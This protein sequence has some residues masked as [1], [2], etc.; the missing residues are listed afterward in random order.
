MF[1]VSK[2]APHLFHAKRPARSHTQMPEYKAPLRDIRF[3][4]HELFHIE[5]HYA[6]FPQTAELSTELIDAMLDEIERGYVG[7]ES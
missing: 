2:R 5:Q 6:R 3:L 4:L 1:A 7:G